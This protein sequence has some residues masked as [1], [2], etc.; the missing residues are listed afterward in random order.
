MLG[1]LSDNSRTL[2]N[3]FA[4]S[5]FKATWFRMSRI[6]WNWLCLENQLGMNVV[7]WSGLP[8]NPIVENR[9]DDSGFPP[10]AFVVNGLIEAGCQ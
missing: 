7:V 4:T 5:R 2:A 8:A 1:S 6:S 3:P 9:F 10:K